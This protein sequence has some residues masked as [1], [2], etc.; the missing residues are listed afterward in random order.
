MRLKI[1]IIFWLILLLD[2]H[3]E[4][5]GW[6]PLASILRRD[7]LEMQ[8]KRYGFFSSRYH[9]GWVLPTND[10]LKGEN[11]KGAPI[12]SFHALSFSYGVQTVGQKEWHYVL[13]FPYYGISFY[14]ANF[15]DS[16]ELGY[17]TAL[18]GFL[19]IPLKR[20]GRNTFG[21]ELG[22]GLTYNWEPYNPYT[23]P[24][25][26]AIGS[27]QTVYVDANLFYKYRLSSGWHLKGGLGFSH[28][29]NGATKQ[30]NNGLNLLSPYV[31]VSYNLRK[32]PVLIRREVAA[33]KPNYELALQLGAGKKQEVYR[34]QDDEELQ[35]VEAFHLVNVSAAMLRQVSWKN[36]YG[37]GLDLSYDSQAGVSVKYRSDAMPEIKKSDI[38]T[39]RM[40]FGIFGAYEFCIDRLSV[41]SYLGYYALRKEF[42]DQTPAVYQKFGLKY[43]FRNNMYIGIL[44]RAHNL[45]IADYIEWNVGYRFKWY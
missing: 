38:L 28:F 13:N 36:K 30:P 18:Y 42:E 23:N 10:F 5:N 21:Y 29:S 24:F 14:N 25:N 8:P 33:W 4:A 44:V 34:D 15:F 22:F 27:H 16:K 45:S 9:A 39:D 12:N 41:A 43:H 26:V 11:M 37:L 19:G 32:Q 31:E 7:S 6:K 3:I 2:V 20:W 1:Q 35:S 17:P 40:M